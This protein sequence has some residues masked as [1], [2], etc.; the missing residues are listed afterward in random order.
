M[1]Q[2]QRARPLYGAKLEEVK[3]QINILLEDGV[4]RRSN[5]KFAAPIHLVK[6]KNGTFPMVG[7]YRMLNEP[8]EPDKYPLPRIH[9][10]LH[11]LHDSKHFTTLDITKAYHHIPMDPN[12]IQKNRHH[13]AYWAV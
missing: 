10:I 12:D 9:D 2:A 6:K 11:G 7:D 3:Q 1:P 5:S 13:H 8:T 4:I